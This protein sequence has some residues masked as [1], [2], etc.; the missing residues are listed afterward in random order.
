ML[1]RNVKLVDSV[2]TGSG[3]LSHLKG[4]RK[5]GSLGRSSGI[6]NK[7][8]SNSKDNTLK[9]NI[10]RIFPN[11]W[12]NSTL[13]TVN[14]IERFSDWIKKQSVLYTTCK[15]QIKMRQKG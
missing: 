13:E 9:H 5:F 8:N 12:S 15:E 6:G 4:E 11:T 14:S 10:V 1:I 7:E 2:R 3:F